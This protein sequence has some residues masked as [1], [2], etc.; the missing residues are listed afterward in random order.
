MKGGIAVDAG[1]PGRVATNRHPAAIYYNYSTHCHVIVRRRRRLLRDATAA[2]LS[3]SM[4]IPR[5]TYWAATIF[6][7]ATGALA[8]DANA[9][10]VGGIVQ[11]SHTRLLHDFPNGF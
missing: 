9:E 6:S 7:T 11:L 8:A 10:A 5:S 3:Y 2:L 4:F 1:R